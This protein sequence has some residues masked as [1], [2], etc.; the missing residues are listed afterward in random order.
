MPNLRGFGDAHALHVNRGGE[1]SGAARRH[2]LAGGLHA[3]HGGG[4]GDSLFDVG[5]DPFA[6]F[7]RAAAMAD[8]H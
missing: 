4:I 1:L 2:I 8:G 3:A 5:G 6:Q 7:M